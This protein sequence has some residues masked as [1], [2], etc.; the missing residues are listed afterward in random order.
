MTIQYIQKNIVLTVPVATTYDPGDYM[1]LFWNGGTGAI[2]WDTPP[3]DKRYE[4]YQDDAGYFGWGH[5]TWGHFNWG[6]AQARNVP[7]W[8]HFPWGHIPWGHGSGIL[9]FTSNIKDPGYY[10]FGFITFDE[11]GNSDAGARVSDAVTVS[12]TPETPTALRRVSYDAT[13]DVLTLAATVRF[14]GARR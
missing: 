10:A 12:L 13:A 4:L 14:V 6:H 9:K 11:A 1:R 7:G 8:G 2:D 5:Q 3:D